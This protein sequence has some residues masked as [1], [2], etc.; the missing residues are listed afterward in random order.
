VKQQLITLDPVIPQPELTAIANKLN[1]AYSDLSSS[2][3]LAKGTGL[4]PAEHQLTD[5]L[6]RIMQAEDKQEYEEPYLDGLHFILNQPEFAHTNRMLDL[7]ELVEH[8][9]LL[10]AILPRKLSIHKVQVVIGKENQVEAIRNCSVVIS[11][12]GP[13]EE[14][15]GIIGVVGPTRM[16]Y[17]RTIST[18]SYLSSVLTKLVAEL[19]GRETPTKITTTDA[20]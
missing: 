19:Y 15:A 18:V 20:G 10:R 7:M 11:Q 4:S 13:P 17:A 14:V 8:K 6:V 12:Y 5:C 16:P 3:I 2:Q 9:N 1:E